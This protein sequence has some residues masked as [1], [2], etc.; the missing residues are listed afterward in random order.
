MSD[1]CGRD[2]TRNESTDVCG[3]CNEW[4]E[5]T[6]DDIGREDDPEAAAR[7]TP[8]GGEFF[9]VAIIQ[10][11]HASGQTEDDAGRTD[12]HRIAEHPARDHRAD[13]RNTHHTG[14]PRSTQGALDE[15]TERHQC[16]EVEGD[17][18]DARKTAL[19]VQQIGGQEA[20]GVA[21]RDERWAVVARERDAITERQLDEVGQDAQCDQ[22]LRRARARSVL[23]DLIDSIHFR[24]ARFAV[25]K[26]LDPRAQLD[27]E[28]L[29]GVVVLEVSAWKQVDGF[30]C[31]QPQR[32]SGNRDMGDV[33]I[34]GE[35]R[36]A[37][38]SASRMPD[39]IVIEHDG[40]AITLL[41]KST[42]GT[43]KRIEAETHINRLAR[44]FYR[45][46]T[47]SVGKTRL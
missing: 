28:A 40:R 29:G 31:A 42:P 9:R 5:R 20:P 38:P 13:A 19:R 26:V 1:P 30:L 10:P 22:R 23:D 6:D 2:G 11:E 25:G 43:R 16:E 47:G 46:G 27:G 14:G 45:R 24:E 39:P 8:P 34:T 36:R 12:D 7:K 37:A 18:R 35:D 32:L 15:K 21:V 3:Q 44:G 41:R 4:N 33:A 17:V